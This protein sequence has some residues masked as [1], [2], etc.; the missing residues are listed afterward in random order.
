[1][2]CGSRKDKNLG[3]VPVCADRD[4]VQRFFELVP[5]S[6]FEDAMLMSGDPRFYKLQE[7]LEAR[8]PAFHLLFQFPFTK[9]F[10]FRLTR[11]CF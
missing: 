9:Y 8:V 1:L 4:T 5:H 11:W 10:F 7:A 2:Y 3:P 6:N